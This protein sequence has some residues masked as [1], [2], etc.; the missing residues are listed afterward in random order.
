LELAPS[1]ADVHRNLDMALRSLG[2]EPEA[3]GRVP[4]GS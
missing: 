1:D 4:P 3:G 2:R